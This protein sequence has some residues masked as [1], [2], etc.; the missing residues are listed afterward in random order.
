MSLGLCQGD[1]QEARIVCNIGG[2]RCD[3]ARGQNDVSNIF[4]YGLE[5]AIVD[6]C[7]RIIKKLVVCA[8][9]ERYY[10]SRKLFLLLSKTRQ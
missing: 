9:V 8:F 6:G 10:C 5:E 4:V 2:T 7:D 1:R 3:T